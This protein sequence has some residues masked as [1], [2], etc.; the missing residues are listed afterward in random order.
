M[1]F[2]P[3]YQHPFIQGLFPPCFPISCEG[4]AMF[5]CS[6][7]A[8]LILGRSQDSR[9]CCGNKDLLWRFTPWMCLTHVLGWRGA[10]S[11]LPPPPIPQGPDGWRNPI[12][13]IA[14]H[15]GRRKETL[16][17]QL[18]GSSDLEVILTLLFA[19]HSKWHV[20]L[21]SKV[22]GKEI[23]PWVW[24]LQMKMKVSL[25]SNKSPGGVTAGQQSDVPPGVL[26]W[27]VQAGLSENPLPIHKF[28]ALG[29]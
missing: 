21:N 19:E 22:A 16:E 29:L 27:R 8:A 24:R 17:K 3:G 10:F 14:R 2:A 4:S 23:R 1:I 20:T 6:V 25:L 18:P 15:C 11:S 7:M 9:V 28:H 13:D 12:W 26:D 5:V